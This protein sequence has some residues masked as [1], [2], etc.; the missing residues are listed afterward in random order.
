M[1]KKIYIVGI[2]G[3]GTSALAL[4]YVKNG[5]EVSGVDVGDGFYHSV[6]TEHDIRIFEQYDVT[7][8][9]DDIDLV[10]HTAAVHADNIELI[11]AQKKNIPI[12]TYAEAIGA[13]TR[14]MST[15][16][17]CGTHGKTT[18]TALT[19]YALGGAD[20]KLTA[21]VGSPITAWGG[22][23][24][25][26]GDDV[27]VLEADEYLNKLALYDPHDVIL[28][29]VDF[30]HP[31]FF[32]DGASY[33]HVFEAFVARIP[34]EGLLVACGDHEDVRAVARHARCRVIYYGENVSNDCLISKRDINER[35]QKITL[36]YE[37][38]EY[39]IVTQLFGAHNAANA[40]AA[41]LLSFLVSEDPYRIADGIAQ[42][43]GTSRRFERR[44]ELHEAIMI[45]D[46]AHHPTEIEATLRGAREVFPKRHMIVA[47]HPHTYTRTEALL[48][49]FAQA[50]NIADHVI[51]LDIYGS[52]RETKG[53]V[54]AMHVV[55]AINDLT[56]GKAQHLPTNNELCVWMEKHLTDRDLFITMGA[57]DIWKVYDLV[58]S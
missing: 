53:N 17:V 9:T 54:S 32:P 52:A 35:G 1:K 21:I 20:I 42:F 41:W 2:G 47:F 16:A 24:Y 45:D 29:S 55:E 30:D 43:S 3:A 56:P 4:V 57:G 34:Q 14:E 23:A 44:G 7:H 19:A 50:L 58:N 5:H 25:V 11:A 10:V 38:K 33:L 28:T 6:L 31:D 51:V 36:L 13:L 49:E 26:S 39:E 37:N 27:F 46:Y 48:P 15:I 8:I 22:G 18:T 12:H 40:T